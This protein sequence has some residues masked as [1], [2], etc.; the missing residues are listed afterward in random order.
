MAAHPF[1]AG[2]HAQTGAPADPCGVVGWPN[3]DF[4]ASWCAPSL[5][6][7]DRGEAAEPAFPASAGFGPETWEGLP[8]AFSPADG[9]W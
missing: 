3:E 6:T 9:R 1:D 8:P 2:P 5:G 4:V 7:A